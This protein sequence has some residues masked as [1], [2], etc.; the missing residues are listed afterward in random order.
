MFHPKKVTAVELTYW[1]LPPAREQARSRGLG[2]QHANLLQSSDALV[3]VVRAFEDPSVPPPSGGID[4]HRDVAALQSE[5]A[6]SDLL[7]LEK[8]VERIQSNL[9]GAKAQERDQFQR[10]QALL[11]RIKAELERDAPIRRQSVK[12]EERTLLANYQFLTA[13]PL[14]I[15][16]NIGEEALP[17]AAAL[18]ADWAAKYDAPGVKALAACAKLE[19]ELSQ[20]GPAEER[21]FRESMGATSLSVG[22][23]AQAAQKLLGLASFL[24]IGEDEVRAWMVSEGLPALKAAGKVHSDMERG[25]I[26]AE[27]VAFDD[28]AACGSMAEA[29]KKGLLRLEGKTYPVKDGDVITILF[30]A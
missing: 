20:L 3:V 1:D 18:E 4:P 26:R 9:K 15:V 24:T 2:G 13:K 23:V 27:V 21:E 11:E 16:F 10:E 7:I 17:R 29:R 6:F 19:L 14:L 28:L 25:F 12:D 5:L 8:R 22:R 30:N